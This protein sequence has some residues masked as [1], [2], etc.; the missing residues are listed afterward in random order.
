[1]SDKQKNLMVRAATGIVF[2]V[3][4]VLGILHPYGL[5]ALFALITGATLWEYTGLANS[6]KGVK[7]VSMT[8]FS[9]APCMP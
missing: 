6:I 9:L 8:A 3:V 4:M 1:M 5:I 7:V 2:V